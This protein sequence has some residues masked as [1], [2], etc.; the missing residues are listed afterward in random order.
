MIVAKKI[1][2]TVNSHIISNNRIY[3]SKTS[4]FDGKIV[5]CDSFPHLLGQF[6]RLN[7]TIK[8]TS[9]VR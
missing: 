4:K 6:V 1:I 8:H 2:Q 7:A 3:K 9:Q 5:E